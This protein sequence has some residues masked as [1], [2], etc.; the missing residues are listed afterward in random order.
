MFSDFKLPTGVGLHNYQNKMWPFVSN[1]IQ[2]TVGKRRA[3]CDVYW[4]INIFLNPSNIFVLRLLEKD[5][6][7]SVLS[8]THKKQSIWFRNTTMSVWLYIFITFEWPHSK[9]DLQNQPIMFTYSESRQNFTTNSTF[10]I[11][12]RAS[13]FLP[14]P[15]KNDKKLHGEDVDLQVDRHR[16]PN[17]GTHYGH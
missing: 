1:S 3:I 15:P 14:K 13:K 16:T 2:A 8:E 9:I 7:L 12:I 10:N 5:T 17:D 11:Q 4:T 6:E